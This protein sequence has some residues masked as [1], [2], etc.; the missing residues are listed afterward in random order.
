MTE[1]P[2]DA[3]ASHAESDVEVGQPGLAQAPRGSPETGGVGRPARNKGEGS[4][5]WVLWFAVF[6]VCVLVFKFT[7]AAGIVVFVTSFIE[8]V[9]GR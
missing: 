1:I 5:G 4:L 2:R 7:P 8:G 3:A 9:L 6:W